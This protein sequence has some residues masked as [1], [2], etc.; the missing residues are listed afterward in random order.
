MAEPVRPLEPLPETPVERGP[1]PVPIAPPSASLP[2]ARPAP[3][4][5][6][7]QRSENRINTAVD[8]IIHVIGVAV[9]RAR[10]LPDRAAELKQRVKVARARCTEEASDTMAELRRTARQQADHM[11]VRVQVWADEKPFQ[12]IAAGAGAAFV[13]GFALRVWRSRNARSRD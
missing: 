8:K 6:R 3:P 9:Q 7:Y 2:A 4:A 11:R 13:L 1:G 10:E 12:A 5:R